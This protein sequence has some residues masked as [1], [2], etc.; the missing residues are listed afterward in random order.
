MLSAYVQGKALTVKSYSEADIKAAID[1]AIN[2]GSVTGTVTGG[3]DADGN[4]DAAADGGAV[5]VTLTAGSGRT[6]VTDEV[7]VWVK[8]AP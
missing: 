5:V 2:D 4:L 8:T 6:V 3:L 1:T 7:T